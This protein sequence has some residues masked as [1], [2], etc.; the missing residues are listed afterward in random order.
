M[1]KNRPDPGN[2]LTERLRGRYIKTEMK[3]FPLEGSLAETP[4]PRLLFETWRDERSGRLRLRRDE[5]ERFLYFEKGRLCL[6]RESFSERAFLDALVRKKVLLPEQAQQCEGLAALKNVS[7][8]KALGELGVLSPVPLWSLLE[9]FV[10]RQLFVLFDWEEGTYEFEAAEALPAAGSFG[11]VEVHDIILQGVRQMQ[12]DRLLDRFLPGPSDPIRVAAPYFLH[13][14]NL[15]PYERYGLNIL[16]EVPN[17]QTFEA[18]AELGRR[19]SRKVLYAFVC[20]GIIGLPAE[21]AGPGPG[22]GASGLEPGRILDALDEKC[23]YVFKYVS[24]EAGPVAQTILGKA[25]EEIKP[26]LG[27]IFQKLRLLAD[28]RVEFD[29]ALRLGASHLPADLFRKLLR[30]YDEILMAEVLAVRKTLGAGHE[31]ALVKNLEKVGC[32]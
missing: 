11:L 15:E 21:E 19:E 25:L 8:V 32:V 17:L 13:L 31:S 29:P 5:E 6:A 14:L 22:P 1:S 24:K 3:E 10:V 28:G 18:R 30:G 16:G 20:L 23:A 12:N 4:F 9:S 7:L 27:P 2:A 26:V